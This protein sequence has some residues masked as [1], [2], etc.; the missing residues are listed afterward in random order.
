MT[1]AGIAGSGLRAHISAEYGVGWMHDAGGDS[2]D[3]C[4]RRKGDQQSHLPSKAFL[5]AGDTQ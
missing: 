3:D 4:E 2:H 1:Y 5:H